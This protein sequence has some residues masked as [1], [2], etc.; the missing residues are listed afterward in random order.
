MKNKRRI[1]M[2]KTEKGRGAEFYNALALK[3][4]EKGTT[5]Q[6]EFREFVKATN[7]ELGFIHRDK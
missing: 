4:L 6:D 7:Q 3:V 5:T 2:K 1:I